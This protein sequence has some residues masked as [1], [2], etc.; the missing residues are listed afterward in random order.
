MLRVSYDLLKIYIRMKLKIVYIAILCCTFGVAISCT[1]EKAKKPLFT[2]D[3]NELLFNRQA[4]EQTFALRADTTWQISVD[5]DWV[6]VSAENGQ[7]GRQVITVSVPLYPTGSSDRKATLS[8]AA[9][10]QK[11]NIAVI[12]AATDLA[13][14][15]HSLVFNDVVEGEEQTLLI[16]SDAKWTLS[17]DCSWLSISDQSGETD[18]QV[19]VN[20]PIN[21]GDKERRGVITVSMGDLSQKIEVKQKKSN[22]ILTLI[23]CDTIELSDMGKY[24][25][26]EIAASSAWTA[27]AN[28]DWVSVSPANGSAGITKVRISA[29]E[30][31]NGAERNNGITLTMDGKQKKIPL[32]QGAKGSY[33]N[34]GDVLTLYSHTRGKGVPVVLIGDGFD[35]QDMKKGGWWES[36]ARE[37]VDNYFLKNAIVKDFKDLFDIHVYMAESPERGVY[38]ENNNRFGCGKPEINLDSAMTLIKQT[39]A[40]RKV[41]SIDPGFST[42]FIGNG[43]IGG[44]AWFEYRM[45]V[46]STAEPPSIYWMAHEFVGHG[47]SGL[48]DEYGGDGTYMSK[49]DLHLYQSLGECLNV[50]DTD[51][52]SKVPWKNFIGRKGYEEIGAFQGGF[53]DDK[54]VWRPEDHSVMVCWTPEQDVTGPYYNAMSRWMIY[55]EILTH[56]DLPCTFDDFLEFDKQ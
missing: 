19:I 7:I 48:A 11:K 47:F 6:K 16:R 38:S 40:I 54:N 22:D 36:K 43:M 50:A 4:G 27:A 37:L 8:I 28:D 12:Q 14:Y 10:G 34:D 5:K 24:R 44:Y 2:I 46:Y 29:T 51:D 52:F 3:A 20:A 55:K 39:T 33:W 21:T 32:R 45:G 13:V 56:A 1:E 31:N 30:N 49:D 23:D 9:G 41:P 53:Y 17:S 35:R 18:R 25:I 42:I 26:Y 15:P